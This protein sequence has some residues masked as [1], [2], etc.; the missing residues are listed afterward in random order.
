MAD[1]VIKPGT[2]P[3]D[4][5]LPDTVQKL[6]N[7]AAAYLRIDGLDGL[8]GIIISDTEPVATDRDKAWLKLDAGTQRAIGF[9][10]YSGGW[11]GVPVIIG[12]GEAPPAGAIE[13]ELFYNTK[14]KSLQMYSSGAWTS[15][16]WAKGA[17]ADRPGSV[18]IGSIF[19]DTD[20]S[21]LLR[22]SAQGWT[23]V[24]GGIGELRMFSDITESEALTRNPGW[25]VYT[26]MSSR[27]PMGSGD[28]VVAGETGGRESFPIALNMGKNDSLGGEAVI[29]QAN[30][31]GASVGGA[32]ARDN[33]AAVTKTASKDVS[34]IP[35]YKAVIFLRKQF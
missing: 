9:Y 6:V 14:T 4:T 20:I 32:D 31:D 25:V 2:P 15:E 26:E 35:P 34:I 27:F 11:K 5:A 33:Y 18:P 30:I 17:T 23:T 1:P 22:F 28:D 21:R 3:V 16:L 7:L 24:D 19:F 12:S 29:I 13:G 8:Q 10:R